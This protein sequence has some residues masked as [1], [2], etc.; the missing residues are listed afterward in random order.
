MA[1]YSITSSN[2]IIIIGVTNLLPPTQIQG[3]SADDIFTSEAIDN[4]ETIMGLDGLLSAGYVPAPVTITFQMMANSAS[5]SFFEAW[6]AA[7]QQAGDKYTGFANITVPGIGRNYTGAK[8]FLRNYSP[9]ASARK[10]M[11]ARS[12]S[13]QFEK[14][15]GAAI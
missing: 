14:L 3:Y 10:V 5:I 13:L 6:F 2:S 12:F 7:E 4:A 9:L 15:I 11:E 8:C 1:G